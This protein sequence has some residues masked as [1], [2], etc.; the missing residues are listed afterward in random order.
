M[1]VMLVRH[2][3]FRSYTQ[4]PE[5]TLRRCVGPEKKT[6]LRRRVGRVRNTHQLQKIRGSRKPTT[7]ARRVL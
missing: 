5:V 2:S 7:A 1:T 6:P 4:Q 3:S